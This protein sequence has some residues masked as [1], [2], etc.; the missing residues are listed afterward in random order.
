MATQ[1]ST[2]QD[3]A[4]SLTTPGQG[5]VS[6]DPAVRAQVLAMTGA[7]P[8][9]GESVSRSNG[10]F[11]YSQNT[12]SPSAIQL[13]QPTQMQTNQVRYTQNAPAPVGGTSGTVPLYNAS[14]GYSYVQPAGTTSDIPAQTGGI[15]MNVGSMP[16]SPAPANMKYAWNGQTGA[17]DLVSTLGK[18]ANGQSGASVVSGVDMAAGAPV[19]IMSSS[20]ARAAQA[21]EA[22]NWNSTNNELGGFFNQL[23]QRLD[24]QNQQDQQQLTAE[25]SS[26]ERAALNSQQQ[27]T[28]TEQ[29]L[30]FRLGR[31]DTAQGA[32]EMAG[33]LASQRAEI[34]DIGVKY[35]GLMLQSQRAREDGQIALAKEFRAAAIQSA[36]L[37]IQQNEA[38]TAKIREVREAQKYERDTASNTF[39]NM[40]KAG[41]TPSSDY[42]ATMDKRNGW[43]IGT[44]EL[45]FSA[46]Q[47]DTE[48]KMAKDLGEQRSLA[49]QQ[50]AT[51]ST[52]LK[53]TPAGTPVKI[54][55][56]T[57]YGSDFG[58]VEHDKIG[59]ARMKYVDPTTG[60]IRVKTIGQIGKADPANLETVYING[61]AVQR[62]KRTG[63][64][65]VG[66]PSGGINGDL[67]LDKAFND[68]YVGGQCGEFMHSLVADYPFGLN[69]AEAKRAAINVP[70]G[71]QPT[72][73][74][75][76]F[77][78]IGPYGHVAM[79]NW[80]GVDPS[81]GK[82]ILKLTESNYHG[83]EKVSHT[84][85]VEA[86]S[87]TIMGYGQYQPRPVVGMTSGLE[88]GAQGP[89]QLRGMGE[90]A[91]EATQA[92]L[93]T[94]PG[95]NVIKTAS[96]FTVG[97]QSES[98]F[99]AASQK[100]NDARIAADALVN[101]DI[102]YDPSKVGSDP[103]QLRALQIAKDN[104]YIK[105]GDGL[106]EFKMSFQDFVQQRQAELSNAGGLIS[107][108][109]QDLRTEYDAKQ[110][111]YKAFDAAIKNQAEAIT[112]QRL[113][114]FE[115][116]VYKALK[117]GDIE[118]AKDRLVTS[119]FR[120]EQ[121]AERKDWNST[122]RF[123][124][125]AKDLKA[126]MN[127][128]DKAGQ[129]GLLS[130][131]FE[132][133][134]QKLGTIS[135]STGELA[136]LGTRMQSFINDYR[137]GVTGAAFTASEAALYDK[138][139]PSISKDLKLNNAL[140]DGFVSQVKTKQNSIM[141]ETL[142]NEAVNLFNEKLTVRNLQ[143]GKEVMIP[144][145]MF[146]SSLYTRIK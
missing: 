19:G 48:M 95:G 81:T 55:D 21:T 50:Q 30:Q 51:I 56:N 125:A 92:P 80:S 90:S 127:D 83:D 107:P 8:L 10:A 108:R 18:Y 40:A 98:Q 70:P 91:P 79:V 128:V 64:Q 32:A 58:D 105:A 131:G 118:A 45:M 143:T 120:G 62:D 114:T 23:S 53:N 93:A 59:I 113:K 86:D 31:S 139:L 71:T 38:N 11:T 104:G 142:G 100:E 145:I 29:A 36:Q 99:Q 22:N 52:I 106:P 47:I 24:T 20:N 25:R 3:K 122:G 88:T 136:N 77:Q 63:N 73:G 112:P 119:A 96:P 78:N 94:T 82:T 5:Y 133:A 41:F 2:A 12:P 65:V 116:N 16:T 28:A 138:M 109:E 72:A 33:L 39:T 121:V 89:R 43:D 54:G 1:T 123:I 35:N 14:T 61:V 111:A 26:A 126:L 129:T 137:Q 9:P 75:L 67:G 103:V 144:K 46:T 115:G 6:S 7:T 74:M 69:T 44:S 132:N 134:A 135:D 17:W 101:G 84:R 60:E 13:G 87:P 140:I 110:S 97:T 4:A 37:A 49:L 27:Q 34:A 130:G 57:F 66:T 141:R 42:L 124:N 68:G 146:D 117:S 76:V 15:P 85:V 102:S